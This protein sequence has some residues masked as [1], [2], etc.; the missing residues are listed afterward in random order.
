[1]LFRSQNLLRFGDSVAEN[2]TFL[3][4]MAHDA[5]S[6]VDIRDVAEVAA[7]ILTTENHNSKIY[8]LTS[9]HAEN[10]DEIAE[11]LSSLLGKTITYQAQSPKDFERDLLES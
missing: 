1:M 8:T 4:P 6:L 10:Y 11:T 5:Y 9:P 2:N 7:T 3:A